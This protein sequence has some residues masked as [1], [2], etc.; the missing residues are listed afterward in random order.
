MHE[1][2]TL[3]AF[4]YDF[5]RNFDAATVDGESSAAENLEL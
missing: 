4:Y 3:V 1:H 2:M 5:I